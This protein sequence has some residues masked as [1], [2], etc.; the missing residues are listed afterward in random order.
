MKTIIRL[1]LKKNKI[2]TYIIADII[3]A[4]TML[5]FLFLFAYAPLIE[6][7]DKD[8]AIFSGYNNLIPL[9]DVFNMAVFCVMSSVMYSKF[10][11]E[12]YSGKRPILLFSYP[13]SRKNVVLSKLFIVCGFTVISM[14]INNFIIF[15]IFG[16]TENFIHLVGKNF[17]F[18]II[19][20][21]AENTI[22]M[23]II[24]AN[25]GIIAVGAGFI[26][27]SVPTTIVS[28]VLLASLMCNIVVNAS[29]NKV[30]IYVLT[31]IMV[32]I[33]IVCSG[34]LIKKINIMEV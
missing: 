26:K 24:A 11:I 30:A 16:I 3:I 33:G 1:E 19:L 23:S 25:I 2:S 34:F 5:G 28:A 18:H 15:L 8:M 12:D 27:K 13:V 14:F 31:V 32:I 7:G 6:P 9:F 17:T 22:I 29:I 21:I 4:I 20:Q 10:V